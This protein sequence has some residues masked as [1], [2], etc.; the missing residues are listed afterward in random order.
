[1][2]VPSWSPIY[3]NNYLLP[4][5]SLRPYTFTNKKPIVSTGFFAA[6]VGC[7]LCM[8]V[9]INECMVCLDDDA[10]QKID[11]HHVILRKHKALQHLH[12]YYFKVSMQRKKRL[13]FHFLVPKLWVTKSALTMEGSQRAILCGSQCVSAFVR[14]VP[15][16][17]SGDQIL[18][19]NILWLLN[20]AMESLWHMDDHHLFE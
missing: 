8:L 16:S 18:H 5:C 11:K 9:L 12:Q 14:L 15:W 3:V 19:L 6:I 20:L 10:Q 13:G 1:M 4:C 7:Y 2:L 17:K